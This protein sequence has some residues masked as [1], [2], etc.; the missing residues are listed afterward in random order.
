[1]SLQAHKRRAKIQALKKVSWFDRDKVGFF[2]F[3]AY[4]IFGWLADCRNYACLPPLT[5][6]WK[7][8]KSKQKLDEDDLGIWGSYDHF[9]DDGRFGYVLD[10]DTLIHFDYSQLVEY[11]HKPASK[12]K[13]AYTSGSVPEGCGDI[14]TYRNILGRGWMYRVKYLKSLNVKGRMVFWFD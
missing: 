2:D 13:G 8:L 6:E 12:F 11:R 10:F 9:D 14:Q 3:R 4:V 5:T 1:M 7:E